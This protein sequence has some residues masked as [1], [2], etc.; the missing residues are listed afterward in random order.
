[1]RKAAVSISLILL[2]A[3]ACGTLQQNID[4][5]KNLAKC[6]YK[7]RKI[8]L[9]KVSFKGIKPKWVHFDAF[10]DITNKAKSEVALDSITG[11]I[12]LD[13]YK[14]SQIQH[15]HFVRIQPGEIKTEKVRLKVD[16]GKTLKA[17]SKRP[18]KITLQAKVYMTIMIGSYTLKTPFA[19]KVRATFPIPWKEITRQAKKQGGKAIRKLGKKKKKWK[20]Y[21]K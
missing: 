9:V 17:A 8:E 18:E 10:L 15:K 1:M 6:K 3:T 5:R 13:R 19:I 12:F 4:A 20:K 11:D 14:T 7:F 21:F 16:F 2:F